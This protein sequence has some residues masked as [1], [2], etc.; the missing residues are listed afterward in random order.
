MEDETNGKK[1]E[2]RKNAAQ[3]SPNNY[4]QD[5]DCALPSITRVQ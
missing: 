1:K 5:Y 4:I 2:E 3:H